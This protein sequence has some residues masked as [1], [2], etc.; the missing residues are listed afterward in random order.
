MDIGMPKI[1]GIQ[2]TREIHRENRGIRIIGLSMYEDDE[3]NRQMREVGASDYKS[4]TCPATELVS[5]VRGGGGR[6]GV[7]LSA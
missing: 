1:N 6:Q 2:A 7:R 4:K 5:A 3:H